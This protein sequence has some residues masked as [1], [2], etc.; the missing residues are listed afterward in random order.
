MNKVILMG[1]LTRDPEVKY[2]NGAEVT[3]VA[4]E[5]KKETERQW[6]QQGIHQV[7]RETDS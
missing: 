7:M 6:K 2:T 1:R 5:G 3:T 4:R